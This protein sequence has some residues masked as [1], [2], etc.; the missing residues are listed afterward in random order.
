M[1]LLVSAQNVIS[2]DFLQKKFSFWNQPFHPTGIRRSHTRYC[3]LHGSIRARIS[4]HNQDYSII[5]WGDFTMY[6]YSRLR[7]KFTSPRQSSR[8]EISCK[9]KWSIMHRMS[10]E[11]GGLQ[12][13]SERAQHI[14]HECM[15]KDSSDLLHRLWSQ[16][17]YAV[18]TTGSSF[19]MYKDEI[20][21]F[22]G[23]QLT[24]INLPLCAGSEGFFDVLASIHTVNTSCRQ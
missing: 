5:L 14:R 7:C 20:K 17:V 6:F 19:A 2:S 3:F 22:C 24:L 21:S 10:L 13:R 11:Y 23:D 16:M 8:R 1:K 12:Y 4:S 18:T 9:S 15:K